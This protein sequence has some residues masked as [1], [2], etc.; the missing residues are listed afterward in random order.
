MCLIKL[1]SVLRLKFVQTVLCFAISQACLGQ[2]GSSPFSVLGIGDIESQGNIRNDGMGGVGISTP[3]PL[4][5]NVLNPANLPYNQYTFFDIGVFTEYK[6]LSEGDLEQTDFGGNIKYL[7]FGFPVNKN[8]VTGAG[9]RPFSTVNFETTTTSKVPQAPTFAEYTYSY[10]GGITQVY[11]SNGIRI[12]KG[13]TLG[14][15]AAYNFGSLK[16]S[17]FSS[18]TEVTSVSN[19]EFLQRVIVSD[20]SF[21][22]G[23]NYSSKLSEKMILNIGITYG[24]G[25]SFNV[26]KH[27][28]I[29][30]NYFG[31][32]ELK[33][34]DT[35]SNN[36]RG[37]ITMPADLSLGISLEKQYKYI[38]GIDINRQS[39]SDY[40]DFDGVAG[41]KN[42]YTYR[43]GAEWV[44][45][46]TS[47]SSYFKRIAYRVGASLQQL[48]F[49]I[50]GEQVERRSASLGFSL[51]V[52]RGFSS[53]NFAFIYGT[54]QAGSSNNNVSEEFIQ[55]KVG[56]T[57]NDRWFVRRR[58]N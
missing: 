18:L 51:P 8:W 9:L 38:I 41:L 19:V 27:E 44:P 36:V 56:L 48:P 46:V 30:R 54:S 24:F 37:S 42:T 23:I 33:Q 57:V 14:L 39:W 52:N 47:V 28:E 49:T 13:V 31:N 7:A 12:Y 26:R 4:Y 3:H 34:R 21:K 32:Q 53:L 10:E 58:I 16:T 45:D 55:V 15:E 2:G 50:G 1:G 6:T 22:P 29:V 40:R 25:T 35:L 43:V 17:S 5:G 20:F 11:W